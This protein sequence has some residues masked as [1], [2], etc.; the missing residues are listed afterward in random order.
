MSKSFSSQHNKSTNAF[1]LVQLNTWGPITLKHM[2]AIHIFL[3]L[4]MIVHEI[5]E[6]I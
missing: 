2:L 4:L 3:L 6:C 1:D 5:H